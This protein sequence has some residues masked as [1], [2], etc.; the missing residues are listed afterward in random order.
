M[1]KK[2]AIML[3][4]FGAGLVSAFA[5]SFGSVAF[6]K[7]ET[8]T[9]VDDDR[10][11]S[12]QVKIE[13]NLFQ[14]TA[15]NFQD[16]GERWKR[17]NSL[18]IDNYP[19]GGFNI[20]NDT[21]VAFGYNSDWFGGKFSIN[22]GGLGGVRAW[23]GF[24]NNKIKVSAGNDIGYGYADS[25]GAAAGLRVYD[26]HL[27]NKKDAFQVV[28]IDSNKN[29]DNITRDKG[30]LFEFDLDP[31]KI[32]LA[33]GGNMEDIAK[34][35]GSVISDNRSNDPLYGHNLQYGLNVGGRIGP[36]VRVNGAYIFQTVKDASGYEYN[37]TADRIIAKGPD[38]EISTHTFGVF[39]SYYPFG[40]DTL[41][42]TLGYAGV[43]EKYLDEFS[44]NSRTSM[45]TV[46]KNG[47]NLTA[48]YQT[49]K[50]IIKTDHNYS[51]WSDKN[52]KIYYLYYPD[53]MRMIDYGLLP[54]S[55]SSSE[56]SD[57]N[58]TFI[59][60][61]IGASYRFT[62]VFEGSVY[63][64][65]LLRIDET[66]EYKMTNDYFSVELKATFYLT[67]GVEVFAGF[68]YHFTG[69]GVSES[70]AGDLGEFG[71][72]TP[73]ATSDSVNMFQIP[74]GFSVKLQR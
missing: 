69:R 54:E 11:F 60:N 39:A 65:N 3:I 63:T 49:D 18:L 15:T 57:I 61:G 30:I 34:N 72:N 23:I 16:A 64:R 35:M 59:W 2:T 68:T 40:N 43:L 51:F 38:S 70:L 53:P 21:W 42:I 10:G 62:P 46:L 37:G 17:T 67:A 44:T 66:P 28:E 73:K 55:S 32:A 47:V 7:A 6:D 58:H 41:G 4:L 56:V 14:V 25:Q 74:V 22:H 29:P 8:E 13:T 20:F 5:Q 45:P 26:D 27:R 52:Y 31:V 36:S 24:L 71:T 12:A 19:F 9:T 1:G 48:R 33:G 50:F